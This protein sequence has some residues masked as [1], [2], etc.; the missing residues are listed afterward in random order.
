LG[1]ALFEN[2]Y[3]GLVKDS[4]SDVII[5]GVIVIPDIADDA[6]DGLELSIIKGVSFDSGLALFAVLNE[7]CEDLALS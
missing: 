3:V 5:P 6:D 7:S 4:F 1:V 2:A